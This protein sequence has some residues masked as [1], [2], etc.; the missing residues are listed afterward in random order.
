MEQIRFLGV[1]SSEKPSRLVIF[2]N[3]ESL[4]DSLQILRGVYPAASPVFMCSS[5]NEGHSLASKNEHKN[6]ECVYLIIL[7][8][9]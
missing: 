7:N 6:I 5:I 3:E 4:S 2:V 1:M 9:C 8:I